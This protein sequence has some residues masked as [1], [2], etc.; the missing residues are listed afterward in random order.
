VIDIFGSAIKDP[1]GTMQTIRYAPEVIVDLVENAPEI[2]DKLK[3]KGWKGVAMALVM[4]GDVTAKQAVMAGRIAKKMKALGWKPGEPK[5][6]E[7]GDVP[8]E[9]LEWLSKQ[10]GHALIE[11]QKFGELAKSKGV[12]AGDADYT[13][14]AKLLDVNEIQ[15]KIAQVEA[16]Y[17]EFAHA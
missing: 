10:D 13:I 14:P 2:Y 3:E 9:Y 12:D 1:V 11:L 8:A 6:Q 5:P 16:G 4:G 17:T 15:S 7:L